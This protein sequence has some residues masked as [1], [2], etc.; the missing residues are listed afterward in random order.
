MKKINLVLFVLAIFT[1]SC[2]NS[3][4]TNTNFQPKINIDPKGQEKLEKLSELDKNIDM[5]KDKY[6][7]YYYSNRDSFVKDMG[8]TFYINPYIVEEFG[9]INRLSLRIFIKVVS[10]RENVFDKATFYDD[11]GNKVTVKFEEITKKYLEN[12][13]FIEESSHGLISPKDLKVFE[14][15][16]DNQNVFV[17]FEK[18]E[19]HII[20]LPYPVKNSILDVIRKYKV[21]EERN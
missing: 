3:N 5:T 21:L 7:N 8:Y 12:S 18:D 19:K 9:L 16:I 20:K 2:I 11:K 4:V 6:S 17:I 13:T 14:K 10:E 15:F 1:V